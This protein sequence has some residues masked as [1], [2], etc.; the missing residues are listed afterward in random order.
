MRTSC[1][2]PRIISTLLFLMAREV[3][4]GGIGSG[5]STMNSRRED[6]ARQGSLECCVHTE[7]V[8]D[9]VPVEMSELLES[10]ADAAVASAPSPSGK[11]LML[12]HTRRARLS[13]VLA[14]QTGGWT[15][16]LL[17]DLDIQVEGPSPRCDG[18]FAQLK[19]WDSSNGAAYQ[20][21]FS[22]WGGWLNVTTAEQAASAPADRGGGGEAGFGRLRQHTIVLPA[23]ANYWLE[24]MYDSEGY[25]GFLDKE[26]GFKLPPDMLVLE[27]KRTSFDP[28]L[29][30]PASLF[31]RTTTP[32]SSPTC[33]CDG[34]RR[35]N[36]YQSWPGYWTEGRTEYV[37]LFRPR[38][39][40]WAPAPDFDG[41]QPSHARN[42]LRRIPGGILTSGT[43]R[44]RTLHQDLLMILGPSFGGVEG[45]AGEASAAFRASEHPHSLDPSPNLVELRPETRVKFFWNDVE[46]TF[47][48]D[49]TEEPRR[50]GAG[51][52]AG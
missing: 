13:T 25:M 10:G 26:E 18:S 49:P 22:Y 46:L 32:S 7:S 35:R 34:A 40:S 19:V 52:G 37:P 2:R 29:H 42:L 39:T 43:S 27:P 21:A 9:A 5:S 15:A 20:S 33:D 16:V 51:V 17:V 8:I 30:A 41:A 36:L 23:A 44:Q 48:V 45:R 50:A 38:F 6:G 11:C 24:V 3:I 14:R 28:W 1:Q 12:I 4:V 31:N 47:R